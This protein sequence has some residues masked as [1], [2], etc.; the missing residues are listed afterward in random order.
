[1]LKYLLH[2]S[3]REDTTVKEEKRTVY[4]KLEIYYVEVYYVGSLGWVSQQVHAGVQIHA[5][6]TVK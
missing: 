2:F 4:C 1:M 5:S 6:N 3:L